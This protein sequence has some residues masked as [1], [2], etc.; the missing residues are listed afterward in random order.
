MARIFLGSVYN[1]AESDAR[2][3]RT[4]SERL[5]RYSS[6]RIRPLL[7]VLLSVLLAVYLLSLLSSR[8]PRVRRLPLPSVSCTRQAEEPG[9]GGGGW[10]GPACPLPG[11]GHGVAP[12]RRQRGHRVPGMRR[13]KA[14]RAASQT[15]ARV[16][17]LF[18]ERPG[19]PRLP[20][21]T[22]RGLII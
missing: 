12:H 5:T 2:E 6:Q 17:A 13:C 9:V 3:V 7:A 1:V 8:N 19:G 4:R 16:F 22:T 15:L 11:Q 10:A 14:C 21:G 20:T 18:T